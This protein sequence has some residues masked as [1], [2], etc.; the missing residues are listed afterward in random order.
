[1]NTI[2]VQFDRKALP[3]WAQKNPD[4]VEMCKRDGGFRAD[5]CEARTAQVRRLLVKEAAR[6]L[7]L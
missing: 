2:T 6:I 5:V 1:M 3:E 7:A 4:V